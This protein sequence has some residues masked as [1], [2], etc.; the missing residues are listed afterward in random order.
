MLFFHS[1]RGIG[2]NNP[3]RV[4]WHSLIQHGN[5][6][7]AVIS[8]LNYLGYNP[9]VKT[10]W[11]THDSSPLSHHLLQLY[12]CIQTT[13]ICKLL[14]TT[15]SL[16]QTFLSFQIKPIVEF[17]MLT[18]NWHS[19]NPN[20][21]CSEWIVNGGFSCCCCFKRASQHT[22]GLFVISFSDTYFYRNYKQ[23]R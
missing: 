13:V 3:C 4:L 22:F 11:K 20:Y 19:W 1:A 6:S 23:F 21:T 5:Q 14:Q 12:T 17:N 10:Y 9:N 7:T 8:I 15:L 16:P 2:E 18:L